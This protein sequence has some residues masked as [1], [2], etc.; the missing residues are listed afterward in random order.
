MVDSIFM[1]FFSHFV[2]VTDPLLLLRLIRLVGYYPASIY[3]SF[4]RELMGRGRVY[5]L[6]G[7]LA[8]SKIANNEK[9]R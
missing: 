9:Y 2:T 8:F 3:F 7:L 6:E 4:V 1:A 5:V